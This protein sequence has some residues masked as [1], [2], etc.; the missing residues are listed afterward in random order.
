MAIF[1]YIKLNFFNHLDFWHIIVA[2]VFA[3]ITIVVARVGQYFLDKIIEKIFSKHISTSGKVNLNKINTPFSLFVYIVGF[4]IAIAVLHPTDAVFPIK[5][6]LSLFVRVASTI[7]L[8]WMGYVLVDFV[9][10][11]FSFKYEQS[12][13]PILKFIPLLNILLKTTITFAMIVNILQYFGYSVSTLLAGVGILGVAVSFASKEYIA[14]VFGAFAI[15]GDG[16][17]KIGDYVVIDKA[18]AGSDVEGTI[19]TISL[20]STKIRALDDSLIIVPNNIIGN[21]IV[22]NISMLTKR[23]IY[24]FVD[25]TYDT[26]ANK[27]ERAVEICKTVAN[28][29]PK[30]LKDYR[31]FLNKLDSSSLK[32]YLSLYVDTTEYAEYLKVREEYFLKLFEEF[33]KEGIEFAFP[34]ETLYIKK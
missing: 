25:V 34:T 12:S 29:N 32:I 7:M 1:E 11:F 28:E 18:V 19:E 15:I 17:Y 33:N 21:S 9:D 5:T 6:G 16:T 23:R 31:V 24:E 13:F 2:S 8:T 4:G 3:F 30:I 14:N 10:R 20:R 27:V 26:P 22:K